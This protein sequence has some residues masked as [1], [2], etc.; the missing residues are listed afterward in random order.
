MTEQNKSVLSSV[1]VSMSSTNLLVIYIGFSQN[2]VLQV[3]HVKIHLAHDKKFN[4]SYS[5]VDAFLIKLKSPK[6]NKYP[7]EHF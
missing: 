4:C 7:L 1:L 2:V 6:I 3:N 5:I